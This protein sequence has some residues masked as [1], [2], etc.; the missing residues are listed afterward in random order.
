MG[1][2][3][4]GVTRLASCD[5]RWLLWLQETSISRERIAPKLLAT[6]FSSPAGKVTLTF[7]SRGDLEAE[8]SGQS[9][10]RRSVSCELAT[11][12]S[13]LLRSAHPL[14]SAPT[15]MAANQSALR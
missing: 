1:T 12:K 11:R 2:G 7:E 14:K 5:C 13:E 10:H 15:K 4:S 3:S 9:R 6:K 8:C